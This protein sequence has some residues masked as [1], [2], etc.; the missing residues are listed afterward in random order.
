MKIALVTE[1]FYPQSKGGTE[2]YVL[3]L[4][5]KLITNNNEVEIITI[6]PQGTTDYNY[7]GIDVRVISN[8]VDKNKNVISGLEPSLNL[9]NFYK[10]LL[11]GKYELV[12][13]H[14]LTTAF[15]M[16]HINIASSLNLIIYFTA[17][18]PS[19]TCIHGDLMLYGKVACDG[20]ISNNRCMSCYL[21]KRRF[22]PVLSRLMAGIIDGF[23]YPKSIS[24]IVKKK[25]NNV[26]GLNS[27]CDKIFIFTN[28]Q[29][30]IFIANGI[31]ESKLTLIQQTELKTDEITAK[32][33][34]ILKKRKA[35]LAYVG[36]MC[37]EKG[38]HILLETF[39]SLNNPNLELHIAAIV[40][41]AEDP[42]IIKMENLAK[43][44][45]NIFW[46]YNLDQGEIQAFYKKIDY[47]CIP[48]IWYETGPYVLYEAFNNNIPII[49]NNLGDME[50][51]KEKG[52][53][54]ELYNNSSELSSLLKNIIA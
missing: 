5:K 54:I 4:G 26:K 53:S 28:W 1:Y 52:Y 19:V 35:K 51:W 40:E 18:V 15:S 6:A 20:E 24:T 44:Q 39:I 7:K 36:R 10:I 17:H 47:L 25:Q 32:N 13:F 16:H 21:S 14:S 3:E 12:H 38:V 30:R 34:A 31:D 50:I 43:Q 2:K 46:S 41:N 33:P 48:S 11:D 22:S 23:N 45:P 27:V 37:Y 49:A 9:N 42:Y 29:K 8:E